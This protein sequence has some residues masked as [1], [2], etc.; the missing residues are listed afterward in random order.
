M[1]RRA[2]TAARLDAVGEV[3]E[4]LRPFW[5]LTVRQ[6]FYQLVSRLL[7]P[8]TRADYKRLSE[9][10]TDGREEGRVPWDALEDRTRGRLGPTTFA[11]ESEFRENEAELVL[12]GYRRD[13]LQSQPHRLEFW[14]EK[15][16]L[17]RLV[18]EAADPFCVDVYPAKGFASTT[19]VK[20]LR[21]RVQAG[22]DE[23]RETVVLYAGDLDPSG[24]AMPDALG[25]KARAPGL[26]IVRVGLTP[27]QVEQFNLPRSPDAL[28][29][30]DSRAAGYRRWL[31]E[32]G[33]PTDLAV[34]LDA[35]PPA[36]LQ[37]LVRDSILAH[38]DRAALALEREV[39]RR[40][41]QALEGLR[42]AAV[43]V[44]RGA[45]HGR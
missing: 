41:A 19:A 29:E 20:G 4:E 33:H 42:A 39:E 38:V 30:T 15:D 12:R 34:E 45:D 22:M 28:K 31:A 21:D 16:A 9:L 11:D 13:V 43:A 7:V 3:L 37:A 36:A 5:P 10:L 40:E 1:A 2:A 27:E 23:G 18:E 24:W 35:L 6:C 44:L 14:V 17:S 32:H 25:R 8:N 26:R